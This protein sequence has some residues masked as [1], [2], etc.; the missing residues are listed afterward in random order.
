M[1][2]LVRNLEILIYIALVSAVSF[3]VMFMLTKKLT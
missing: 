2:Y 3:V 1:N